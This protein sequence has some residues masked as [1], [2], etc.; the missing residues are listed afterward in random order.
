[1]EPQLLTRHGNVSQT[2]SLPPV[3]LAAAVRRL[4]IAAWA[5][6]GVY[7]VNWFFG[8]AISGQL[9]E[10]LADQAAAARSECG[11]HTG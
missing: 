2:P 11:A 7:L 1:M 6:L 3:L 5:V 8:N 4:E 9:G 10:E